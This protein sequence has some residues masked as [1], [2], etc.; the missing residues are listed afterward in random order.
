MN[1]MKLL[2]DFRA[3]V[4]PPDEE[5]LARTRARVLGGGQDGR[6]A[7]GRRLPVSR[8]R[9]A[10]TGLAQLP[11]D[12]AMDCRRVPVEHGRRTARLL[13]AEKPNGC[14]ADAWRQPVASSRRA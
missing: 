2:E 5:L 6:G 11:G 3:A 8:P 12:A 4:A 14:R 13:S 10:L 9:L 7:R 1:E